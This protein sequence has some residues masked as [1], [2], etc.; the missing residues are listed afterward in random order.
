MVRRLHRRYLLPASLNYL[1]HHLISVIGVDSSTTRQECLLLHHLAF[2]GRWP[3]NRSWIWWGHLTNRSKSSDNLLHKSCRNSPL[4]QVRASD[5]QTQWTMHTIICHNST[6]TL[7]ISP[8]YRIWNQLLSSQNLLTKWINTTKT[9]TPKNR[10]SRIKS[11]L[12]KISWTITNKLTRKLSKWLCI[13]N[14]QN[15]KHPLK[16]TTHTVPTQFIPAELVRKEIWSFTTRT[17]RWGLQEWVV[18]L[19]ECRVKVMP[20]YRLMEGAAMLILFSNQMTK[21]R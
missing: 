12:S 1:F 13:S 3:N 11:T 10:W 19:V 20:H 2:L 5:R 15:Y 9:Y 18:N 6:K 7:Q 14:L 8:V 16:E 17:D 21:S 4:C